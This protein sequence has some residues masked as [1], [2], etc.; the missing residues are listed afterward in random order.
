MFSSSSVSELQEAL[1]ASDITCTLAGHSELPWDPEA[2]EEDRP[3]VDGLET[4]MRSRQDPCEWYKSLGQT[5]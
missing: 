3:E 1:G 2:A 4:P 5:S